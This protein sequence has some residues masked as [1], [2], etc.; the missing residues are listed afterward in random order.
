MVQ[1]LVNRPWCLDQVDFHS[2][3]RTSWKK[4]KQ[5]HLVPIQFVVRLGRAS[6]LKTAWRDVD[7]NRGVS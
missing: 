2:M 1:Q 3:E 7:G 6:L 4:E 5:S